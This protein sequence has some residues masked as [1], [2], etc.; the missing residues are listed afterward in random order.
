MGEANVPAEQPPTIEEARVSTTHVHP[1]RQGDPQGPP[2]KGAEAAVSLTWSIRDRA[3]FAAMRS[4]RRVRS[5]PMTVS[6]VQG[7]PAEPPRVAYAIGRK[8]GGAVER[9]RLRRRLRAVVESLGPQLSPGAYLIR[10]A[11][12]ASH[13]SFE[14]LRATVKHVLQ[15]AG[16]ARPGG[17]PGR[18]APA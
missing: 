4:A 8:V 12:E 5:G 9:N 1:R 13:L 17:A 3:T 10:V 18:G 16:A 6:F 14:E 11:P 2:P 15:E 7:N